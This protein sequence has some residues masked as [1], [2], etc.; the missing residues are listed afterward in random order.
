MSAA[1]MDAVEVSGGGYFGSHTIVL[2]YWGA[3]NQQIWGFGQLGIYNGTMGEYLQEPFRKT[4]A[5]AG[6]KSETKWETDEAPV[7]GAGA[8][9]TGPPQSVYDWTKDHC[10]GLRGSFETHGR[11]PNDVALG[12]D[13]DVPDAPLK[14]RSNQRSGFSSF[15]L[16]CA[17]G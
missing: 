17:P 5:P 3:S 7:G 9:L 2:A 8:V 6:E 12:C 1:D 13:P 14:V 16:D 4:D 15:S 11:C 10:P